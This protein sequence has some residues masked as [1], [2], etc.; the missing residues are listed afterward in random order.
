MLQIFALVSAAKSNF[1]DKMLG[2]ALFCIGLHCFA[3]F[4][5]VLHWF[6]QKRV[7]S[8]RTCFIFLSERNQTP[9]LMTNIPLGSISSLPM[10]VFS[11][12][13]SLCFFRRWASPTFIDIIAKRWPMYIRGP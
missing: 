9:P 12:A 7:I 1:S 13:T 3:L 5:I 2:F 6:V 4:C 10:L 8:T 11:Q